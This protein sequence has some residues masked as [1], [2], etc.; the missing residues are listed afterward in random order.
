MSLGKH[1]SKGAEDSSTA[2]GVLGALR[3]LW[4]SSRIF[5]FHQE[6]CRQ[7]RDPT[8]QHSSP[9]LHWNENN[10]NKKIKNKGVQ[11]ADLFKEMR[12]E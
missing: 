5:G 8:G 1:S 4:L 12:M 6:G 7:A 2:R 9:C 11:N 10:N 3:T